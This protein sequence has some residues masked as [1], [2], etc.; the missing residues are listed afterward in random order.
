MLCRKSGASY[1]MYLGTVWKSAAELLLLRRVSGSQVKEA[2][3][4][5]A[6]EHPSHARRAL[7]EVVVAIC[8]RHQRPGLLRLQVPASATFY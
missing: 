6:E 4:G 1:F 7:S 3:H 2:H 5:D 8:S